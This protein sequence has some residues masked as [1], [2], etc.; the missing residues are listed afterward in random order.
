MIWP[1]DFAHEEKRRRLMRRIFASVEDPRAMAHTLY[2]N[3]PTQFI[4]DWCVTYN[5]RNPLKD[6][7]Y[8]PGKKLKTKMPFIPFAKQR[9]LV[10]WLQTCMNNQDNG[11]IEKSRDMG[12][13]WMACSFSVWGM[14]HVISD[15]GASIIISIERGDLGSDDRRYQQNVIIDG[16]HRATFKPESYGTD[17]D[18]VDIEGHL[19]TVHSNAHGYGRYAVAGNKSAMISVVR[20]W[21]EFIP[22]DEDLQA[23]NE[24]KATKEKQQRIEKELGRQNHIRS[25][26]AN[27]MHDA[28][29]QAVDGDTSNAIAVLELI[30]K[31]IDV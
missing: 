28:L 6:D 20:K 27:R 10:T 25:R 18:L 31:E 5:P 4:N 21:F 15:K 19:V 3:D 2:A 13:T 17:Y 29:Q 8:N 7:P 26:Y 12:A 22:T 24:A 11:L 1:P 9:E 14:R 30:K 23:R 16:E